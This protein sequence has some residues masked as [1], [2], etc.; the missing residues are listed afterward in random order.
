MVQNVF[1]ADIGTIKIRQMRGITII[2]FQWDGGS[3]KG[4]SSNDG[5]YLRAGSLE[6]PQLCVE[7]VDTVIFWYGTVRYGTVWLLKVLWC[8]N[9]GAVQLSFVLFGFGVM[10]R[11]GC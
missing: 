6:D 9:Y 8:L 10:V 4:N 5:N 11:T 7:G 1:L 2:C 3:R